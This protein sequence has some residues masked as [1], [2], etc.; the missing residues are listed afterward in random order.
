MKHH[1]DSSKEKDALSWA[2]Q[3]SACSELGCRNHIVAIKT[4]PSLNQMR[5]W[6]AFCTDRLHYGYMVNENDHAT[7]LERW[8]SHAAEAKIL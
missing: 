7:T 5:K 2:L 4:D 8:L 1:L 3:D 6:N